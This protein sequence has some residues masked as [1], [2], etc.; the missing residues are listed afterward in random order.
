MYELTATCDKCGKPLSGLVN[1]YRSKWT[2]SECIDD[3]NDVLHCE[4]GCKGRCVTKDAGFDY[5]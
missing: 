5:D 4:N 2:C 3:K 1:F